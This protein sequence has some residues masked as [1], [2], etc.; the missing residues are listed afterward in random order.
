[1]TRSRHKCSIGLNRLRV[2]W[3]FNN[4]TNTV[5]SMNSGWSGTIGRRYGCGGAH[6]VRSQ[7]ML[8]LPERNTRLDRAPTP[9]REGTT[10]RELT[11]ILSTIKFNPKHE[12]LGYMAIPVHLSSERRPQI[13][14]RLRL[15]SL[16]SHQTDQPIPYRVRSN[17]TNPPAAHR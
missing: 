5:S 15:I 6:A 10:M 4:Q 2:I 16:R 3:N 8:P 17:L 1:M 12:P 14:H 9:P 7:T 13:G 11:L